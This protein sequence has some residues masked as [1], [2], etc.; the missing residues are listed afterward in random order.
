M[1]LAQTISFIACTVISLLICF[2]TSAFAEEPT[3]SS[4]T[5]QLKWKHKFQFAGYYAALHKGFFQD[6]GLDVKLAEGGPGIAP[7]EKVLAGHESFYGVEAG[8]LLYERL[9]GKPLIAVASIY[10]HSPATLITL[11]SA[12]LLTPHDLAGK[13]I[14]MQVKQKNIVEIAAMFVNEGMSLEALNLS[15]NLPHPKGLTQLQNGTIDA[16]YGYLTS[17]PYLIEKAGEEAGYMRPLS[18]G[19]D[20]YG[21]VLFTTEQELRKNPDRVAAMHRAVVKGW[22]YALKNPDEIINLILEH[23]ALPEYPAG[24]LKYEAE[25]TIK[26]MQ[27]DIVQVG[28]MNPDR[29]SRMADIMVSLKLVE[30]TQYFDGFLYDPDNLVVGWSNSI[31]Y[32]MTAS[33]LLLILLGLGLFWL[34]RRLHLSTERKTENLHQEVELRTIAEQKLNHYSEVLEARLVSRSYELAEKT[35]TVRSLER[36]LQN[37]NGVFKPESKRFVLLVEDDELNQVVASELLKTLGI[38]SVVVDSG[39]QALEILEEQSF[40]L[41][42][43]DV[44]LPGIDGY[45]TTQKIRASGNATPIIALTAHALKGDKERCLEAGMNDY[46]SKPIDLDELKK[47]LEKW[48]SQI[49]EDTSPATSS[50]Y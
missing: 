15:E 12:E 31:V 6:E 8:E 17:E 48:Q 14:A 22:E 29:W 30:D 23:Y 4:V 44:S 38:T 7:I 16:D 32:M 2:S 1:K 36:Q 13:N 37:G 42:F 27:P 11:R 35:K 20:F 19:I 47:V 25:Q 39:H 34:V 33:L 49:G 46:L 26:L 41:I 10:Q 9:Q 5:L 28:H 3:T 40:D 43:M 21:D 45:E 50:L 24:S 18:Y